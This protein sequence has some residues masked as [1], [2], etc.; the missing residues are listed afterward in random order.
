M[1]AV[2]HLDD[3]DV[4]HG[5]ALYEHG[6]W[7][8]DHTVRVRDMASM[9]PG[10]EL[11]LW[12]FLA[13]IDLTDRVTATVRPDHPLPWALTDPRCVSSKGPSDRIW[14][15]IL[16]VPAA[17]TARPWSADGEVVVGVVDGLGLAEG[18][19]S[20]VVRD[21]RAEV[22][23]SD[24]APEVSLDVSTLGSLYLGV[25]D[26]DTMVATGRVH[27]DADALRTWAA[28]SDGGPAPYS[29]TSFRAVR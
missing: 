10:G 11:A 29:L 14:V 21:G 24:A 4:P 12:D 2:V 17:L 20:V 25:T 23:A 1:R 5:Y 19:W 8:D 13:G 9:T 18:R 28:M 26:V 3:D 22:T 15:R 6:G 7:Q 16:D 27:G